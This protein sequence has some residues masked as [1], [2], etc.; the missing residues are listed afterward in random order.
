[1]VKKL[2]EVKGRVPLPLRIRGK[3]ELSRG[4]YF[5][6]DILFT[7]VTTGFRDKR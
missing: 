2:I 3:A 6:I 5:F 1:M 4:F 7:K